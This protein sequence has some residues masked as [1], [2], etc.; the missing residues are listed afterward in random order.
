MSTEVALARARMLAADLRISDVPDLRA[1]VA[2]RLTELQASPDADADRAHRLASEISAL[3]DHAED[4]DDEGRSLLRGAVEYFVLEDDFE[5]GLLDDAE[6]VR[7]VR[8]ELGLNEVADLLEGDAA[9]PHRKPAPAVMPADDE[10]L[11]LIEE[12]RVQVFEDSPEL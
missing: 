9:E 4:L 6:V 1:R 8:D 2:E 5:P 3:L 12:D 7:S 10:A 11:E